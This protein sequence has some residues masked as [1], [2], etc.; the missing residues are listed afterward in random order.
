MSSNCTARYLLPTRLIMATHRLLLID[1]QP[2][3]LSAL[4]RFL[5]QKGYEVHTASNGQEGLEC[6]KRVHPDLLMT[7]IKMPVMDG[8]SLIKTLRATTEFLVLPIIILTDEDEAVT[9]M[10]GYRLGADDFLSKST[11]VD[12]VEVRVGRALERSRAMEAVMRRI[13]GEGVRQVPAPAGPP[14]ATPRAVPSPKESAPARPQTEALNLPPLA[15]PPGAR[16]KSTA[17]STAEPAASPAAPSR[18]SAAASSTVLPSA[19]EGEKGAEAG[20]GMQGSLSEIGLSSILTLLAGS[21]KSGVL[22]LTGPE[23][24]ERGQ[25]IMRDGDI[26]RVRLDREPDLKAV[27]AVCHMMKWS[28]GTFLFSMQ[29]VTARDEVKMPAEHLLMEASRLVDEGP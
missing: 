14:Q 25:V 8:W 5:E 22:S 17:S 15:T 24:E 10:Q 26:L 13:S 2:L 9:R 21:Q 19:G 4:A 20:P 3:V 18:A 28:N 23:E 29:D 12:E 16:L 27:D 7:D 6:A 1:D 11:I